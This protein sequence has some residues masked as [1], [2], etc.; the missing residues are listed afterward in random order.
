M[1]SKAGDVAAYIAEVP[2]DRQAVMKKLRALSKQIFKGSEESMAYGMPTYQRDGVMQFAFAS[3]KQYIAIYAGKKAIDQF[4]DKLSDAS[5][6]KGCI[7]F[8]NPDK[9]DFAVIEPLLRVTAK[10]RSGSC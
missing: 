10:S 3:Q 8:A 7:R 6:G 9:I 1:I 5:L 4:R 2:A